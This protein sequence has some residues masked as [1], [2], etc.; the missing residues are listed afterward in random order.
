M[1]ASPTAVTASAPLGSGSSNA[2][3]PVSSSVCW[4]SYRGLV[5]SACTVTQVNRGSSEATHTFL[6]KECLKMPLVALPAS[7]SCNCPRFP[8]YFALFLYLVPVTRPRKEDTRFPGFLYA[9]TNGSE[10]RVLS[11]HNFRIAYIL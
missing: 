2:S 5:I 10:E 8:G 7:S 3:C 4:N 1:C 11:L 6:L 9:R